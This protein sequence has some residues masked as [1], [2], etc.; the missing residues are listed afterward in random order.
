MANTGGAET[1]NA[2]GVSEVFGLKIAVIIDCFK[3]FFSFKPRSSS[4]E[5]LGTWKQGPRP[6]PGCDT[7]CLLCSNFTVTDDFFVLDI[8]IMYF[9]AL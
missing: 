6:V 1:D 8:S 9:Y 2:N 7:I 3:L 5:V 4:S